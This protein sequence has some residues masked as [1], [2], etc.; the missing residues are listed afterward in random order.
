M[1]VVIIKVESGISLCSLGC[2]RRGE[3]ACLSGPMQRQPFTC[4]ESRGESFFGAWGGELRGRVK[5]QRKAER[6]REVE[7]GHDHVERGGMPKGNGR[8]QENKRR[9]ERDRERRGKQP[10]CCGSDLPGYCQ[11]SVGWS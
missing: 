6:R 4:W 11:V 8:A 7:A 1:V 2:G 3:R 9:R 10:L 5:R